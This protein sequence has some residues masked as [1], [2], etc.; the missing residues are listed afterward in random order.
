MKA[1]IKVT[2]GEGN[3]FGGSDT[4]GIDVL[5]SIDAYRDSLCDRLQKAFPEAEIEVSRSEFDAG[6]EKVSIDATCPEDYRLMDGMLGTVREIG[7]QLWQE[8]SWVVAEA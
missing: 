3:L 8:W 1:T 5:A 2:V 6:S 4:D 7:S